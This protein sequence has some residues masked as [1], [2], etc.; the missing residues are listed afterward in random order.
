MLCCIYV[1]KHPPYMTGNGQGKQKREIT[2]PRLNLLSD[3]SECEVVS[4]ALGVAQGHAAPVGLFHGT[5]TTRV[6]SLEACLLSSQGHRPFPMELV[7]SSET[8]VFPGA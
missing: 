2:L 1:H 6:V 7:N 5:F 4:T 8:D 3:G